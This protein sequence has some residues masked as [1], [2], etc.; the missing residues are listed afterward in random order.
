MSQHSSEGGNSYKPTPGEVKQFNQAALIYLELTNTLAN[1]LH[2]QVYC[3]TLHLRRTAMW[4]ALTLWSGI[5]LFSL[6]VV[7]GTFRYESDCKCNGKAFHCT[8]DP[9]GYICLNCIDNT[10][11]RN[12]EKCKSGFFRQRPEDRCHPCLCNTM[13]SLS[14]QCDNY[15][16]CSCKPGVMGDKC[17]RCQSGSALTQAG[18]GGRCRSRASGLG[19]GNPT[20]CMSCFCYGHSSDCTFA[21]G[22][23]AH[24]ITSTFDNDP[25]GWRASF[26][27]GSQ[28]QFRWS[29]KHRDVFITS[30]DNNPVYL[31]APDSFLGNQ[32]LSYGQNLSFSFS[33]GR[34]G[35]WPSPEDVVLEGAG[36]RVAAPLADLGTILP[37]GKMST[38]TF[39]LDE[40]PGTKWRPLLSTLQFHKLLNNLTAIKIRANYGEKSY[41]YLDNVSLES[42]RRGAG[43]PATWVEKCSCPMGYRGQF[44]QE[45]APGYRRDSPSSGSFSVCVPCNCRGGTCDQDTGDCYS[46]DETPVVQCPAGTYNSPQNPRTCLRCPCAPGVS[47]VI[48]PGTREVACDRCPAG[49]TG[50]RCEMC[51]DGYY[52]DPLGER[53][54]SRPCQRCRCNDNIDLNTVGNCDRLS[55]ECLRCLYNTAGFHCEQ[56]R[57]GFY[58][59]TSILNPAE[60]C[61]PCNCN[62]LGSQSPQCSKNGQC[63]CK[64]GH[65]GTKCEQKTVCPSCYS[66]VKYQME[67]HLLKL[68]DTEA[69]FRRIDTSRAPFSEMEVEKAVREAEKNIADLQ[70]DTDQL[71]GSD[72]ALL[73]RL[74]GI[75]NTQSTQSRNLDGV[76]RTVDGMKALAQQYQYQVDTVKGLISSARQT[77]DKAK[78]EMRQVELPSADAGTG[79]N[80]LSGLAH[81]A[82]TL[83]DRHRTEAEGIERAART[84]ST[85]ANEA[86]QLMQS[87]INGENKVV[88]SIQDLNTMYNRDIAT[89]NDLEN[90]AARLSSAA[91]RASG[92]ATET[93]R[94]LSG[95]QM[96]NPSSLQNEMKRLTKEAEVLQ[97]NAEGKLSS[98]QKL[99]HKVTADESEATKLL[100]KGISDQQLG[101]QLLARAN[102]AKAEALRALNDG[103]ANLGKVEDVLA[104]LQGF[105]GQLNQNRKE[106]EDAMDKI[107]FIRGLVR[108]ATQ[109]NNQAETLL[110]NANKD[111]T[112]AIQ[113]ARDAG[114]IA[115]NMGTEA[116]NSQLKLNGLFNN[117][118]TLD[119]DLNG[120]KRATLNVQDRLATAESNANR[121][122]ETVK[123][124]TKEATAA[125]DSA[126]QTKGAVGDTLSI[127][128]N[129][130][131]L[132]DQPGS[133]DEGRLKQLERSIADSMEKVQSQLKPRMADLE[134]MEARQQQRITALTTD[135]DNILNDIQNLEEIRDKI[136]KGCY[137]TAPIERP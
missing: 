34:G 59:S 12:C 110:G 71:S 89:V 137:N 77:V 91:E 104:K 54:P 130:L 81:E 85:S 93:F 24:N 25:D 132:L 41:G 28:V 129:L 39:R 21:E 38:Y 87:V 18:C 120:L 5:F 1:N 42:A 78:V 35:R 9:Q 92:L 109:T 64:E 66:Q 65:E 69:L 105:N 56:C 14:A 62:P 33:V 13:G 72:K 4:S 44:C 86:Y 127:I 125:Y 49:T 82:T 88:S 17:D 70:R 122:A 101:D 7:H 61:T 97:P 29:P 90:Q 19:T 46:G 133:V 51:E 98:I 100:A 103:Q 58:R 136:P 57:E 123:Q 119:N 74:A 134:L 55:G 63:Q 6:P 117:V 16:R 128:K 118:L 79:T 50:S 108:E 3:K 47:C 73:S 22:F 31:L 124:A 30:M 102:V 113:N 26:K 67:R 43:A 115:E 27:T 94:D 99:N 48:T 111:V 68:R 45:C 40:Q 121:D 8:Y 2:H 53:G 11:G 36:L 76:S 126:V 107:P 15:G 75:S 10:D 95:F 60:R 84:S 32:V 106:A 114:D 20:D 83:A 135:I 96:I 112:K 80:S 23:S 131:N 37:C 52:G 116:Q